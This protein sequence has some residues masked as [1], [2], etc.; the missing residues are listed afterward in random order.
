[1]NKIY[2]MN[3]YQ[4]HLISSKKFKDITISVRFKGRFTRETVT[5]RSVLGFLMITGTMKHPTQKDL[6]RTLEDLYGANLSANISSAGKGHII[7]F[8]NSCVNQEFLPIN[9]NL[10]IK[11]VD[12]LNEL[13]N[14][15]Y[16]VDN[17][18]DEEMTEL[19][20]QEITYRIMADMD[21][22]M[23]YAFDRM[24][25]YMGRG[26]VLGLRST[27]YIEDMDNIN[28]YTLV[29]TYKDMIQ[30]DDKHVYVV[31]DI[32]ESIVS[33]FEER[34]QFPRA[35]HEP[36]PTA[37][38]YQN[39]RI[40]LLD[41]I[42]KQDIVQSKLVI[43]HITD[44]E[45][46]MVKTM[47]I[48]ALSKVDDDPDSIISFNWRRDIINNQDTIEDKQNAIKNV[49]KEDV[50]KCAQSIELDT[51]YFLTGKEFYEENLLSNN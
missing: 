50:I 29:E 10:L 11:Q 49:T 26:S 28:A 38:I 14:H 15:P 22:K 44:E 24:V 6:S 31:G 43:G 41:I 34:L 42:E 17:H 18:F 20:K 30:N 36:Y 13:V 19:K 9:E 8:K 23:G 33:I 16:I 51:I 46:S 40:N 12:L 27:G 3:G 48:N 21:D 7:T 25:D 45:L 5:S 4:L 37:Y 32:D 1:M 39:E 47:L 35:V 2:Q